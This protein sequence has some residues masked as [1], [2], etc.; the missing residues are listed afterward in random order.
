MED[1]LMDVECWTACFAAR[2]FS[3]VRGVRIAVQG[4]KLSRALNVHCGRYDALTNLGSRAPTS[5]SRNPVAINV[6][7]A[8]SLSCR[9]W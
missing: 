8:T 9:V 6:S 3:F 4:V 2:S 1:G 7:G 5:D